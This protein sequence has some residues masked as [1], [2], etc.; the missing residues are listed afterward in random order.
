MNIL[1]L[2]FPKKCVSCGKLGKYV[3]SNCEVGMWEEEQ[4]CPICRRGSRYGLRHKYCKGSLDGLTCLWAYEGL[5]KKI[6]MKAKYKYY[7]DLLSELISSPVDQ[8][9]SRVELVRFVEFLSEKPMIVPVPL[10]PKRLSERGFN[11]ARVVAQLI[12]KSVSQLEICDM[13]VR[14]KDTG[15][16]VGRTRSERLESMEGAFDINTK[17]KILRTKNVLLIDDVWTTGATM[18]ECAKVLKKV[19]VGKVWGLV[20]AR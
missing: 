19:G 4:I 5:V 1:D 9:S 12:S 17:D 20:L 11:Q 18:S 6:I 13:L 3:C 7:Y 10:H 8:F 2:I 15:R 14:I 16:Q